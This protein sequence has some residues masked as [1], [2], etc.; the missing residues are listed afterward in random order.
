[1]FELNRENDQ[2][3]QQQ[4]GQEGIK[5]EQSDIAGVDC[6]DEVMSEEEGDDDNEQKSRESSISSSQKLTKTLLVG[7]SNTNSRSAVSSLSSS[8]ASE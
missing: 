5:S 7:S 3:K 8:L 1:M 4:I 2:G 6:Q